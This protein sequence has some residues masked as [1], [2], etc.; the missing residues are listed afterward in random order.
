MAA[1]RA[2]PRL[3]EVGGIWRNQ[4]A[5]VPSGWKFHS[6]GASTWY[7]AIVASMHAS[8]SSSGTTVKA[9][10]LSP[11]VFHAGITSCSQPGRSIT[12]RP[13]TWT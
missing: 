2:R 7:C 4:W 12:C 11:P 13:A 6:V 1:S 8:I 9:I 3:S 10:T 5:N